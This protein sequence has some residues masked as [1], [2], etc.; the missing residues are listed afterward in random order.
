MKAL[1]LHQPWASLIA[2][3]VKT[4]ETRS[5]ST[6]YRGPLAIHAGAKRPVDRGTPT[7][8][9]YR[10]RAFG[11]SGWAMEGP[12]LP[13]YRSTP[14]LEGYLPPFG[15]IVATC[16]LADCVPMVDRD[17]R[18]MEK[19]PHVVLA[20]GRAALCLPV[21]SRGL[22]VS[23]DMSD[24]SAQV[25]FGDF[26]PGRYAWLLE[27]LKPTTERCPACWGK[28]WHDR[29]HCGPGSTSQPVGCLV[30]RPDRPGA[31]DPVPAR[32]R[33]QLWEWKP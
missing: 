28:G 16:T 18:P 33:Q 12:G 31:S 21:L 8:G 15:A 20:E 26:A 9:E 5:W 2:L 3:G 23:L 17:A 22:N 30:C 7:V 1:T 14:R 19:G 4:V 27:D 32:G 25:P 29:G 11:R 6:R 13:A 10:L 24:L